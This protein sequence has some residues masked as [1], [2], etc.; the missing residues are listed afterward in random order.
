MSA[1]YQSAYARG[2]PLP[3]E[4]FFVNV[5]KCRDGSQR[6]DLIR[7]PDRTKANTLMIVVCSQSSLEPA[8]RV[9]VTPK[10]PTVGKYE[11][12]GARHA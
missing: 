11:G 5:Y 9:R 10:H 4:P 12:Q 7:S 8:F 6:I 1:P 3:R 2:K